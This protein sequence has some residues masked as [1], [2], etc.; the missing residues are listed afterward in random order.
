MAD[1]QEPSGFF[2]SITPAVV[3]TLIVAVLSVGSALFVAVYNARAQRA[4]ERE[5][6]ESNLI[7]K[8]ISTGDKKQSYDN[9]RF[10]V[11]AHLIRERSDKVSRLIQDTTFHFSIPSDTFRVPPAVPAGTI[12]IRPTFSGRVLDEE[13]GRPLKGATVYTI[14]KESKEQQVTGADGKFTLH[15]PFKPFSLIAT[16]PGHYYWASRYLASARFTGPIV[17]LLERDKGLSPWQRL[18]KD[19]H[20]D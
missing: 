3:A 2:S 19:L 15:Y 9:L 20:L 7:L 13:T 5:Q 11:E 10:L 8:A 14:T 16:R 18:M 17:L 4:L 12:D 1:Q 6:F